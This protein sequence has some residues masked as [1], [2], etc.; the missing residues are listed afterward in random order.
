MEILDAGR[1]Y[2]G[3]NPP[4]EI[5]FGDVRI[6]NPRKDAP[7]QTILGAE[8][9]AWFKERLRKSRA[10]WKIWGNSLGTLDWRADP[11]NLPAGPEPSQ[12]AGEHLRQLRRRRLRRRL[13]RAR[14]DLR[15]RPRRADHRLRHRLGRP[16]QLLGR[17]CRQGAAARRR[18]SRSA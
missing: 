7:P 14:R 2:D 8:Q 11:Q 5:R 13:C 4:A 16:A 17:L 12:W 9:K 15:P 3:G 18:S 6:A 10:T 1:A